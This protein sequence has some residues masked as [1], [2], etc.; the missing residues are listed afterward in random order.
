MADP[1]VRQRKQQ[2]DNDTTSTDDN[3]TPKNT[4][5]K[6]K[7]DAKTKVEYE[8]PWVDVARVLTFLLVASCGL[9]YLVTGGESVL[10]SAKVPPK[11]LRAEWW[12]S[13]WAGPRYFTPEQLLAYDGADPDAPVY[14][15]INHSV[16]DVSANRKTYGPGGSYHVF[17][18]VDASRGFVTGCFADDRTPDLRGVDAMFLPLDDPDVDA[19]FSSTELKLLREQERRHAAQKVHDGLKHWVDFFANSP[20][21]TFVGYVRRPADWLDKTPPPPL[22]EQAAK[23]RKPRKIPEDKKK[24]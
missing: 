2:P 7:K 8:N 20:K 3:T 15:A 23:G 24:N 9:S 22:C 5:P 6:T 10:W 21:Y 13:Q 1:Q 19:H 18:G 4:S 16:Y 11:Y 12:R 17:A 14:L